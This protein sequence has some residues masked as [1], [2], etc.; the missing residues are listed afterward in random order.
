MKKTKSV[1]NSQTN[2]ILDTYSFEKGN[3]KI[4]LRLEKGLTS[5]LAGPRH[6]GDA[7]TLGTII[8]RKNKY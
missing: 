5:R 8:V 3:R 2:E 6:I 7:G 1:P 4:V